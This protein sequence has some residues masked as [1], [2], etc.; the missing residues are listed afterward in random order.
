ME[1]VVFEDSPLAEYLEGKAPTQGHSLQPFTTL[2]RLTG[3]GDIEE[4]WAP[5][6]SQTSNSL[7]PSPS[8]APRGRP[9]VQPKFRNKLPTPLRLTIPPNATVAAIHNTCSVRPLFP[10]D[11][12]E[13][14]TD[15][16]L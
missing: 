5:A 14:E 1:A 4:E 12:V 3:E 15:L 8:F 2:T 13:A 16:S 10:W 6:L 9:T 7:P 11:T